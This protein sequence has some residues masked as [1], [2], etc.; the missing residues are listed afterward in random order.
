M[1]HRGQRILTL[2]V[3]GLVAIV[4]GVT[5]YWYW[6][7]R[8]LGTDSDRLLGAAALLPE[9][10]LMASYVTT[11]P[12]AWETLENPALQPLLGETLAQL[13]TRWGEETGLSYR[14]DLQ[15]WIDGVMVSLLPPTAV[16]P[17]G[18]LNVLVLVGIGDPVRAKA[19]ADRVRSQDSITVTTTDYQGVEIAEIEREEGRLYA[20]TLGRYVALSP[21]RQSI[22]RT[23]DTSQGAAALADQPATD[24]AL[25][26][27]LTLENPLFHLY[28]PDYGGLI[29]QLL[30]AAPN[31]APLPP[32]TLAQLEQFE[33]MSLGLG[34]EEQGLR[35][36]TVVT[37]D[38]S[39]ET[40]AFEPAPG[41]ILTHLPD[42]TLALFSGHNL[43]GLWQTYG[44]QAQVNPQL[45]IG[46]ENL[47]RRFQQ[48]GL[49]PDRDLFSWMTGE[50]ALGAVP[51]QGGLMGQLG[52]G[53]VVVLDSADRP[54]TEATLDKL[55]RLAERSNL[56]VQDSTTADG[57]PLT[58][59][60]LPQGIFQNEVLL[61]HG[62]LDGDSFFIGIGGSTVEAMVDPQAMPLSQSATFQTAAAAL[63]DRNAGYFY[64]N[65]AGS[66]VQLRQSPLF[67]GG[68]GQ[69]LGL[70]GS[71]LPGFRRSEVN[72][73]ERAIPG[74]GM[75]GQGMP[76]QD[77][78]GQDMPG[79]ATPE[80]D[81]LGQ[82]IPEQ[83]MPEQ[84]ARGPGILGAIPGET[85]ALLGTVQSITM[86]TSQRDRRTSQIDLILTLDPV[87]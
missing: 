78:P 76:G 43:S 36:Q 42:S 70:F 12:Q 77:M 79:Q 27:A 3:T 11:D 23:I 34:L 13:E 16:R 53:A 60:V 72:P 45:S 41:E 38:E 81:L 2:G 21:E 69:G 63:P 26:S 48:F 25:R 39:V 28:V 10:A 8:P 55:D 14:E 1:S 6:R 22:E 87:E 24:A 15:P 65:V 74:Q 18:S 66:Q 86:T 56:R 32:E 62:W 35:M 84:D 83:D 5:A 37:L 58:Q 31:A 71:G 33:G 73:P 4:A 59:W 19:F 20:A 9:Q 29:N 67:G 68:G 82:G 44:Q 51:S 40:L 61:G 7:S 50:F 75:P 54:T 52:L 80:D 57:Q 64:V 85:G 46:L 47:R 49:D 17:D 30:V